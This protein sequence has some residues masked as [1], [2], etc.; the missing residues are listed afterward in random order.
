MFTPNNLT[1]RLKLP[2]RKDRELC[3]SIQAILGF[4]PHR[5]GYYKLALQHKSTSRHG[6]RSVDENNER[7]EFLGDAVLE[8]IVSDILYHHFT[9]HRE[10][11]LTNTRSKMVQR[12][13][14]NRLSRDIGLD[15]LIHSNSHS[16]AHNNNMGGNAFEALMGAIYLDR[17]YDACMYFMKERILGRHI[18]L[19]SMAAKEVN[20]KSKLIEWAQ[21]NRILVE[22]K[23]IEEVVDPHAAPVFLTRILLEGLDG[24]TGKGYSKKESH[25]QAAKATLKLLNTDKAFVQSVFD[26]K[27][28][29]TAQEEEPTALIPEVV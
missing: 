12:E 5:T 25:Q 6:K 7:L 19:D 17:G 20:F 3:A 28:R 27:S 13:T 15:R 16:N 1:D 18:N 21:K 24:E 26:A 9:Q 14:L 23:L 11:F 4:Y 29:R 8:S 2:F 10:G 22:F